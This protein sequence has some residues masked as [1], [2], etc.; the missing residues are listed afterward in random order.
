MGFRQAKQ[1]LNYAFKIWHDSPVLQSL[2]ADALDSGP[3]YGNDR[4]VLRLGDSTITGLPMGDGTSIRGERANVVI[5]DE[6]ASIAREVFETVVAG[7]GV[8]SLSPVQQVRNKVAIRMMKEL[9]M[10]TEEME[11]RERNS[12]MGNQLI[13]SGTCYYQFNHFYT[14]WR[15]YKQIIESKGD[16]QKLR[17]AFD[18][19]EV[20]DRL[21]HRHYAVIRVPIDLLPEG[22]MDDDQIARSKITMHSATF[23][24]EYKAVFSAD[25][26]GFYKRTTI[27]RCVTKQPIVPFKGTEAV[28]FQAMLHGNPDCKY[29]FGIDPASENDNLSIVVLEM[30]PDHCRVVYCWTT[31][32]QAAK[33]RMNN[34]EVDDQAFYGFVAD[35]IRSLMKLFRC[36]AIALD[37]QGGGVAVIEAL[38]DKSSLKEGQLPVYIVS[39]GHPLHDGKKRESDDKNGLHIV[40]WVSMAKAEYASGA[41]H[42]MRNDLEMQTLL[43]P[44][45]DPA[46]LAI[47][48]ARDEMEGRRYDT[49]E[50]AVM[51]I[52]DLKDELTTITHS[53]TPGQ[54]REHWDTPEIKLPGSK[55]GRLRKDRYSALLMA[56]YAARRLMQ[57]EAPPEAAP[58]G[59]FIQ[60]TQ[61]DDGPKGVVYTGPDWFI[62][63]L[64]GDFEEYGC[65]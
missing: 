27:E 58:Y 20:P 18:G 43:F 26:N 48:C 36:E 60:H 57:T 10:W 33:Q 51:E 16:P 3:K 49:H 28:Q 23:N 25:S 11:E 53:Q 44:Y 40:E 55:K 9:R 19:E 12:G 64:D 62:Q 22:Y 52:E 7:F 45:C 13:I 38:S 63:G 31:N 59:G 41:N 56:N 6:F 35:K 42:G 29:V 39:E 32:R 14:Y 65:L 34:E 15:R 21:N 37:S 30:H 54:L 17:A 1:V 24:N 50:D 5:G 46:V 8:V 4:W 47:A 2:Y 61:F